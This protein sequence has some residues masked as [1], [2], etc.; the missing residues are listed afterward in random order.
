MEGVAAQYTWKKA[1]PFIQYLILDE[2]RLED[3]KSNDERSVL[4]W[5]R[6]PRYCKNR[7]IFM[8]CIFFSLAY[9]AK[10]DRVKVEKTRIWDKLGAI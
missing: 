4:T 9:R 3:N 10:Y 1:V 7:A 6:I 2:T 8:A 5:I